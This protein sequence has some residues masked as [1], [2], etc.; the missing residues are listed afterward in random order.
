MINQSDKELLQ[1][2]ALGNEQAFQM[3]FNRHWKSLFSFVYRLTRDE[4][5]TKD[6]LQDV[7]LYLWKNRENLYAGDSFLPYLNTVARS[8]VMSA[9]R[10]DKVRL[11]GVEVLS[12]AIKLSDNSDEQLLLKEVTLTVDAE[13]SKMPFNMRQCFRLSRYEDKS[14]REIAAELKLSEQT[15]KNN[16]SEALRRLRISVEQ[17]SLIYLSVLVVNAVL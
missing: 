10:K 2:I 6:I 11:Q 16:I 9:F 8:N 5:H 1:D 13:L 15:V 3:L 7:F 14:I 17:G 4:D 12:E